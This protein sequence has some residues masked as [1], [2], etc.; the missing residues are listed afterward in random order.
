MPGAL[1]PHRTSDAF[2]LIG[3]NGWNG[4][5]QGPVMTIKVRYEDI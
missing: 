4:I 2:A 5:T 1:N 3:L